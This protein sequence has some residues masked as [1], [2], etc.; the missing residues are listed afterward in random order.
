[1]KNFFE[2]KIEDFGSY[3]IDVRGYSELTA[4]TYLLNLREAFKFIDIERLFENE[5]EWN[6]IAYR[7]YLKE[8]NKKT[9]SKKISIIRSFCKYLKEVGYNIFLTADDSVKIPKTLPK[10]IAF[11][12]IKEALSKA[13][14]D[15]RIII[16]LIY[17]LGLRIS[18]VASIK[19]ENIKKEWIRIEGKG[20]KTREIPILPAVK[21][22]IEMYL[23]N[24]GSKIYLFE[25]DNKPVSQSALRYKVEKAFKRVGIKA[26]PHQL[27]HS[28]ATDILNRGGRITDVSKLLGHSSLATTEIYTKLNSRHK[29]E[30]YMKSHPM[31]KDIDESF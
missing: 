28:F 7:T 24:S 5:Y 12:H 19:I 15:E 13:K 2:E 8:K 9:I 14:E 21:E 20:K 18:E 10:P 23:K 1:M 22:E 3:L 4:K 26:T 16:F 29:L 17:G 30:S 6:L 25:K 27:R 31:V 11:R